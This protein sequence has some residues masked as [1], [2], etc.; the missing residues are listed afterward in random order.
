MVESPNEE[1]V[2]GKEEEIECPDC[3]VKLKTAL[4]RVSSWMLAWEMPV[5]ECPVR[6]KKLEAET[7]RRQAREQ[8]ELLNPSPEKVAEIVR[9]LRL[10]RWGVPGL[11]HVR[12]SEAYSSALESFA[13]QFRLWSAGERP[14]KG[15]WAYGPT[16]SRKTLIASAFLFDVA[17]KVRKYGLF[18]NFENLM[19]EKAKAAGGKRTE[20]SPEKI[21]DA[22]L[23][24]LDD[25]GTARWTD[26]AVRTVYGIV[27]R[28][29][30]AWGY[31]EPQQTLYVTSNESP[32]RLAAII[33]EACGNSDAGDRIVR[34][35]V[36]L[37]DV[38]EVGG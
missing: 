27:E 35:L 22:S 28:V 36:Q 23:L 8:E 16:G 20:W 24:L 18:W 6:M 9:R 33:S 4:V 1:R 11:R 37:C 17:L 12:P 30:S 29:N 2:L 15:V 13:Q 32:D 25:L 7:R 10:P 14:K 19:E 3:H 5:H 31:T 26:S 38:V 34:R 21:E